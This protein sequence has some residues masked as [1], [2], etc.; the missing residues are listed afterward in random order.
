MKTHYSISIPKPCHEDW[1]QMSPNEKGRFCQSC[2]KSVIDFTT[3]PEEAIEDYLA[4]NS[5]K[6]ICG[7][8]KVWKLTR[9]SSIKSC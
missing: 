3:M 5:N 1:S 9:S 4:L 6:K 8:F 2:S 7:K